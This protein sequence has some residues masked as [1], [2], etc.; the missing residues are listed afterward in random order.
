MELNNYT[1]DTKK[2]NRCGRPTILECN[3]CP[4]CCDDKYGAKYYNSIGENI[5]KIFKECEIEE[6]DCHKKHDKDRGRGSYED[7]KLGIW[8]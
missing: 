2:C 6:M 5:D 4:S 7:E 8:Y 3:L 1:S